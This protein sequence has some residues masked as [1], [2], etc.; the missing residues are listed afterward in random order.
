MGKTEGLVCLSAL[1]AYAFCHCSNEIAL[2][3]ITDIGQYQ[4][5]YNQMWS[6]WN[7]LYGHADT[8][9]QGCSNSSALAMEL[10][11]VYF[12]I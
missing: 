7:I 4:T 2:W 5:T 8:L 11:F 12:I 10:L 6:L 9:V 3:D 1:L